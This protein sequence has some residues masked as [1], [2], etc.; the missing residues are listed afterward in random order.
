VSKEALDL[1]Q[2]RGRTQLPRYAI[3]Y[4]YFGERSNVLS[5]QHLLHK[6][7][8]TSAL[9]ASHAFGLVKSLARTKGK[10]ALTDESDL[11]RGVRQ[12]LLAL[13]EAVL[14]NYRRL[15]VPRMLHLHCPQLPAQRRSAKVDAEGGTEAEGEGDDSTLSLSGAGTTLTRT[16]DSIYD[17]SPAPASP[18][19][20]RAT[21]VGHAALPT[22]RGSAWPA[23]SEH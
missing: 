1:V 7:A 18:A 12:C 6:T 19:P 22:V 11:G 3:F 5:T 23:W 4:K 9:L 10:T 14:G 13:T 17:A 8:T 21:W 20:G 15:N 2:V 16:A